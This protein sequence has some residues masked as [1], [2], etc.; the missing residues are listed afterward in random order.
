MDDTSHDRLLKLIRWLKYLILVAPIV[1]VVLV[2]GCDSAGPSPNPG[3]GLVCTTGSESNTILPL[4]VGNYW[5]YYHYQAG[6]PVSDSARW[7]VTKQFLEGTTESDPSF[8]GLIWYSLDRSPPEGVSL[9]EVKEKGLYDRGISAPEDSIFASSLLYP[10]PAQLG[11]LGHR[12]NYGWEV[13]HYV[14]D[15]S[16]EVELIEIDS[17]FETPAGTFSTY[18]YRWFLP[19]PPDVGLGRWIY[20][21]Y[22]PGYGF[23]ARES[24]RQL[25]LEIVHSWKLN[26]L[27]ILQYRPLQD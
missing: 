4:R 17:V 15:D 10:Y 18:V 27:C 9:Y 12:L 13:D 6:F 3:Q 21:Y 7:A 23:V 26:R 5:D 2:S 11:A 1:L 16:T 22:A 25:S 14:V 19:P 24:R 20:D 8:F